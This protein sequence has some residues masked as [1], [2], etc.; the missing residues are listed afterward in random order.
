MF[1]KVA[2]LAGITVCLSLPAMA[3]SNQS[4]SSS[5]NGMNN[6]A[7]AGMNGPSIRQHIQQDLQKAGY[8]NI[9]V[10]PASF[11]AEAKDKQGD[12][13][14]LLITPDSVTSVVEE[15][16]SGKSAGNQPASGGKMAATG[17]STTNNR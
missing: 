9:K 1:Q 5:N 3:Q 10:M 6:H 17:T 16:A 13:V 15:Q 11:V 14:T 12:P 2:A 7:A 8:T 4:E